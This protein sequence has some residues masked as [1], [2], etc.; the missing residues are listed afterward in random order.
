MNIV[1]CADQRVLPGLHVALYSVLNRYH[2]NS[3]PDFTI[4][5]DDLDDDDKLLLQKTLDRLDKPYSLEFR[6]VDTG[7]FMGFAQLN[8]SWATYYR[9]L[10]PSMLDVER[11]LY[12]DADILC[13]LDVAE[14]EP[15]DMGDAPAGFVSEAPLSG[16]ADRDVA[17]LLGD[18]P[19]EPYFNAGVML[20]NSSK[21]CS[22]K[23]TEQ[24]MEFLRNHQVAYCDQ[25]ALNFVLHGTAYKLDERFNTIVNMRKH[26]PSLKAPLGTLD[27]LLHFVE[28]PKPWDFGAELI[29]PQYQMWRSILDRTEMRNFRSWQDTF[30]RRFPTTPQAKNGYKKAIKDRI[31]FAGYSR[32]ILKNVKGLPASH[33]HR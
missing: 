4:F 17:K 21:W 32:G 28:Y 10:I 27:R 12:L 7:L 31:L 3:R 33:K 26:W 30:A 9:L 24:A 5:S 2:G 19:D 11:F 15:L 25:S 18:S 14:L 29:H 8:G 23:I 1:F 16:C 6:K 22:Q 20:V 13:D